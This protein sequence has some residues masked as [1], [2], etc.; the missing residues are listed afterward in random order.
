MNGASQFLQKAPQG[1]LQIFRLRSG[2]IGPN[3]FSDTLT[4]VVDAV[5]FY[6][7]D[8]LTHGSETVSAGAFPRTA[9]SV[10]SANPRRLLGVQGIV[11]F[12][13]AVTGTFVT[14]Q[15]QMINFPGSVTGTPW[16]LGTF[17]FVP[18]AAMAG[19]A[20][21]VVA[22]LPGPIIVPA[23][24]VT[25]VVVNSDVAGSDH[26]ARVGYTFQRLDND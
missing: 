1:L 18:V 11:T 25:R 16:V 12:G 15:L 24:V 13:A 9:G 10:L 14:M 23:G 7:A 21:A 5:D 19:D 17:T 22:Q 20:I 8:R 2:G 6:G 4:P 26:T 3:Q